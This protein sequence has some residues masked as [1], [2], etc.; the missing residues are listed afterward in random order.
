MIEIFGEGRVLQ[1]E[2]D[3]SGMP[4]AFCGR[5]TEVAVPAIGILAEYD[6]LPGV[7][8]DAVPYKIATKRWTSKMVKVADITYLVSACINAA[9]AIKR[10]MDKNKLKGTIKLF[11]TPAEETVVGKVYMAKDGVFDGMDAVHRNGI[12][13][14]RTSVGFE[15]KYC[16]Q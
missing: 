12:H 15:T 8:N 6:A 13:L 14:M 4:T 9:I 1:F 5:P 11:G 2:R 7:G 10:T 16:T 3:V